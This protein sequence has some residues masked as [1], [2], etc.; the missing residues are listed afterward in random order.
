MAKHFFLEKP[1]IIIIMPKVPC[2]AE[3]ENKV[4]ATEDILGQ[5]ENDS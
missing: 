2:A 1:Q 3:A 5:K 4:K